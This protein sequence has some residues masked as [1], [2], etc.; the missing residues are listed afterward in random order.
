MRD[1]NPDIEP[2]KQYMLD[3]EYANAS[4]VT[5]MNSSKIYAQ[6]TDG[7]NQWHVMKTR[8]TKILPNEEKTKTSTIG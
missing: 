8:L 7:E 3:A 6:I 1:L 2:G 5:V 4:I